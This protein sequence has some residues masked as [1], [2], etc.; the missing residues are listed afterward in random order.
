VAKPWHILISPSR[1]Q[2]P[3]AL[4]LPALLAVA[5]VG[6][7][8][9]TGLTDS[10]TTPQR[11]SSGSGVIHV[12]LTVTVTDHRG[13]YV[14]GLNKNTFSVL[15]NKTPREIVA[16]AQE[17]APA[18]VGILLD[19]SA[20][21]REHSKFLGDKRISTFK[22]ALSLFMQRANPANEYF[23]IAF[24]DTAH[25]I[26][27]PTRDHAAVLNQFDSLAPKGAT[28]LYDAC[29]MGLERIAKAAYTRRVIFLITDGMD[30]MSK[31]GDKEIE[32]LLKE[33]NV[34]L[35]SVSI[36]GIRENRFAPYDEYFAR[37]GNRLLQNLAAITGGVTY[38]PMDQQQ[39]N[40]LFELIALE[41]RSQY[42]LE[43]EAAASGTDNTW[44][45]VEVKVAPPASNLS[46]DR[47]LVIRSRNGFYASKGLR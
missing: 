33:S 36:L 10:Q 9:I 24:N 26:L 23:L 37:I 1:R 13:E 27:D 4:L 28:A 25:L 21:V 34:L 40:A 2:R 3:R 17:D 5:W 14:Y 46:K 43:V 19:T 12:P 39:V 18:T 15:V 6:A 44:E 20:S 30:N 22:Q 35:Y 16:F 42:R 45:R 7:S 31:H 32:R 8:W 11:T 41:M 29:Y 47:R 38:F